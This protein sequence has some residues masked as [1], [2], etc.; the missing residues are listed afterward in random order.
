MEEQQQ[1]LVSVGMMTYNHGKYIRKALESVLMQEVNF[2]YEIVIADDYSTDNTRAIIRWYQKKYPD[3]IKPIF[4]KKNVGMRLNSDTLRHNC[5]GKYR[6][7]L[8]GDDYWITTDKLQKQV[9]FLEN[10]PDFIAIGADFTCVDDYG[11]ACKFPWGDIK[12]TYCSEDEYT[13]QHMEQWLLPGHASTML[14]RNVFHTCSPEM[15]KKFEDTMILGDRRTTLFLILQ[16]RIYHKREIVL[17]RRVLRKSGTSMTSVTTKMNW[18]A[19][20]FGWLIEAERFA[21]EVFHVNIDLSEIKERRWFSSLK[22]FM[23]NPSKNNWRVVKQIYNNCGNKKE[24]KKLAYMKIRQ[25][26]KNKFKKDGF[27]GAIGKSIV[28]A[29]QFLKKLI[30]N[31]H[32]KVDKNGKKILQS[33]SNMS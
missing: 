18:H 1:P 14:F 7:T 27:F 33:F 19:T 22:V 8:E 16:G 17:V 5:I 20:N 12:Y 13:L 29:G 15:L 25:K 32:S 21:R 9:D 4:Q 24:Y 28:Y 6:A 30:R 10:N 11:K 2:K 3:I 23:K 26:I 31:R